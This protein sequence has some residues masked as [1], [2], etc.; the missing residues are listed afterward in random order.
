VW[1]TPRVFPTCYLPFLL[2]EGVTFA[3]YAGG[4]I[5]TSPDAVHELKEMYDELQDSDNAE[6]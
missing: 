6:D 4:F 1:R 3:P 5:S 2:S